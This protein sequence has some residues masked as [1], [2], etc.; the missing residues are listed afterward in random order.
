MKKGVVKK[1]RKTIRPT[2]DLTGAV[3]DI[4]LP[5]LA[6]SFERGTENLTVDC[7]RIKYIDAIGLAGLLRAHQACRDAGG[8]LTLVHV[9]EGIIKIFRILGLDQQV[10]LKPK[11][12]RSGQG[13]A[14]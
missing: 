3:M 6:E 5:K 8:K 1:N 14:L 4:F 12:S 2:K 10:N 13:A 11:K 9:N 7:S